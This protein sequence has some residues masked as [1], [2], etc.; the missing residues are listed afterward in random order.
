PADE[1]YGRVD[2]SWS[3]AHPLPLAAAANFWPGQVYFDANVI[4]NNFL[5]VANTVKVD[6]RT[7]LGT[8]IAVT[9]PFAN[10]RVGLELKHLT[11]N[12]TRDVLGFPLPGRSVFVTLSYGFGR[13]A[14]R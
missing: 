1:A 10:I 7:L 6:A 14:D 12:Q 13:Q 11:N 2:L 8:G 4:A 5:D 3:P 9:V